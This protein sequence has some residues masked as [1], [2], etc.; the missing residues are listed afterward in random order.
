MNSKSIKVRDGVKTFLDKANSRSVPL[1]FGA[2][3]TLDT[4]SCENNTVQEGEVEQSIDLLWSIPE[5]SDANNEA[6]L[7]SYGNA[8]EETLIHSARYDLDNEG[9][10]VGSYSLLGTTV[11]TSGYSN[12]APGSH[13]KIGQQLGN[14]AVLF[15]F[16][17]TVR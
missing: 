10:G 11:G 6:R 17:A 2:I 12:L 5:D 4:D 16:S 9:A 1:H 13:L 14:S 15:V 8:A 3:M 7:L